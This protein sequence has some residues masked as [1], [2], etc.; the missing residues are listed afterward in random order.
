MLPWALAAYRRTIQLMG[1]RPPAGCSFHGPKVTYGTKPSSSRG[2]YSLGHC[3]RM[4][5]GE[6]HQLRP[7]ADGHFTPPGKLCKVSLSSPSSLQMA[8]YL[9]GIAAGH[10]PFIA[11]LHR[12]CPVLP[13]E[14]DPG[15][16]VTLRGN[17]TCYLCAGCL[18]QRKEQIPN[19]L[20]RIGSTSP[21]GC[22]VL[23]HNWPTA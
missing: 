10:P 23:S 17:L 20:R 9:P 5:K 6:H 7:Q 19:M 4:D 1:I 22:G 12:N 8:T 16:V 13:T 15:L 18:T 11:F 21:T 14:R 3:T 2:A